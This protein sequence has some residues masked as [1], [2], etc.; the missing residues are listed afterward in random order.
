VL[1]SF[2]S[3][4]NRPPHA[5]GRAGVHRYRHTGA[6]RGLH[7]QLHLLQGKR[8]M[9]A[10]RRTP[11]V[12]AI[13]LDPVGPVPDLVAHHAGETVHAVSLLGALRCPPFQC[14]TFGGI[15][16]GC[17]NGP[18]RSQHPR[19]GNN[20][21][22]HGLLQFHVRVFRAFRAQI[23]HS[24]ETCHQRR[25]Q[26]I[27]RARSPQ[28]QPFVRHLV[29]PRGLIVGVQQDVRVPFH[30]A[31]QQGR[32]RQLHDLRARGI[33]V[34]GRPR[35]FD[36]AAAHPNGPAFVHRFAVEH[37]RRLQQQRPLRR[38]NRRSQGKHGHQEHTHVSNYTL[39]VCET[40]FMPMIQALAARTPGG[41]LE[42][43]SFDPGPLGDNQVEIEVLYCGL[44]HSDYSIWRDEF[45]F[46]QYPLVPGHEAIGRIVALGREANMLS[47]GQTVGLGW[48]SGSC[49]HCR[50]CLKGDHNLCDN[51]EN[52]IVHRHGAFATRVRCHWVWATPI[53]EGID[54]AK[55]GPLLCGGITVF[56]PLLQHGVLPTHRVG[57]IGIGGLGH[58]ALQFFNKWGCDV[59]AFTSS[60]AKSDEA[61]RMGAHHVVNTHSQEELAKLAGAF[62]LILSTVDA[63]LEWSAYLQALAPKGHLHIVGF[64]PEPIAVPA[65]LLVMRQHSVGG[66]PSGAPAA[67]AD[68]LDFCARHGIAPITEEFP[69]TRV[70]E[71][72]AHLEAGKARY[73][74][75]LRNDLAA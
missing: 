44:C 13:H 10:R 61:R 11:A 1:D 28:R 17:H 3:G 6:P 74:I 46:T 23:A 41:A 30:Q 36:P 19:S 58:M 59:T 45:H 8:G 51:I 2:R 25:P 18:R 38:C 62:D 50:P 75:V 49:L 26:M 64:A 29:I 63:N 66:T 69:M 55:A 54:L 39:Q 12:I 40:K 73:R 47:A 67:V 43:Y 48:N 5:L 68:M 32:A 70:N 20:P 57:V 34:R 22:I 27:H 15:A 9:R 65:A 52:T 14:E 4:Q 24:G 56:N 53:P 7:R 33:H 21:L 31:R 42:P 37:P 71:A 72:L 60:A 16:A 35:R